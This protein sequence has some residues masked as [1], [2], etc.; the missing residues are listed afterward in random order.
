M[1]D[2]T[3]PRNMSS[4]ADFM[5]RADVII[6]AANQMKCRKFIRARDIVHENARLNLAFLCNIFKM[7][8]GLNP[9]NCFFFAIF[10]MFNPSYS[11][12]Y[13]QNYSTNIP[14][15]TMSQ[16]TRRLCLPCSYYIKLKPPMN[17]M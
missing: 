7:Y 4:N 5:T 11:T 9:G 1:V 3:L 10:D 6:E 8:P 13:L 14:L 16:G 17:M 15:K 12:Y 2:L